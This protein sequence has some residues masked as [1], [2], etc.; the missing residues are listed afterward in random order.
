MSAVIMV[1][2]DDPVPAATFKRV[3]EARGYAVVIAHDAEAALAQIATQP[4][5]LVLVDLILPGIDGLELLH[6]LRQDPATAALPVLLTTGGGQA[7][8]RVGA[9]EAE[10]TPQTWF[11]AKGAPMSRFLD[12]IT[13]ALQPTDA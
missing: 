10:R 6:R 11:V 12:V 8:R 13:I 9:A 4:P 3:L 1:V 7:L 5:A 2:E